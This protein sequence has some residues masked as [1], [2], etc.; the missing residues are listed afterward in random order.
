MEMAS[1]LCSLT[2]SLLVRDKGARVKP[3]AA[4][5]AFLSLFSPISTHFGLLCTR[6]WFV[7]N[8]FQHETRNWDNF[9]SRFWETGC[10]LCHAHATSTV[11]ADSNAVLA[12]QIVYHIM[13]NSTLQMLSWLQQRE[14]V[15][16]SALSSC[17]MGLF[18][19]N[20]CLM[21]VLLL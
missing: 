3:G 11:S 19:S 13:S 2:H 5:E 12:A 21:Y 7:K 20:F 9:R 1:T 16:Y 18:H 4:L 17:F 6:I 8:T 15:L 14:T 10:R